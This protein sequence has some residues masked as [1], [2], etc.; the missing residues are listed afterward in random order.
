MAHLREPLLRSMKVLDVECDDLAP[1]AGSLEDH[2]LV[3]CQEC[4]GHGMV[5]LPGATAEAADPGAMSSLGI[6]DGDGMTKGVGDPE[7][8][9]RAEDGV[10]RHREGPVAGP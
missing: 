8:A 9:V 4:A 5:E 1:R 3:G 10:G 2:E 7:H 6:D